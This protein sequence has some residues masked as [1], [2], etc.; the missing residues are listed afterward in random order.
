ME[1]CESGGFEKLKRDAIFKK[2][3]KIIVIVLC[4]L[5]LVLLLFDVSNI[6]GLQSPYNI[7]LTFFP[8]LVLCFLKIWI[9]H[10]IE[11]EWF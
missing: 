6:L 7:Y 11:R 5:S 8:I 3:Y 9:I 10:R 2:T 1:Q 4:S